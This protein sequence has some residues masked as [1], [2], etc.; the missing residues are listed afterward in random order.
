MFFGLFVSVFYFFVGE[1]V[2]LEGL[3]V[4]LAEVLI[5]VSSTINFNSSMASA[6]N[7]RP[8]LN[9]LRTPMMV[10][11]LITQWLLFWEV[12]AHCEMLGY[13]HSVACLTIFHKN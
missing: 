1:G 10:I 8:S 13:P 5:G 7:L 12:F 2:L 4:E 3:I 11:L 6:C 9:L